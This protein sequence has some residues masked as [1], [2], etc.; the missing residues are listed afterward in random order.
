MQELCF[1]EDIM[2][3]VRPSKFC[4]K[5]VLKILILNFT[6]FFGA[7]AQ[8]FQKTLVLYRAFFQVCRQYSFNLT[9]FE[10][11]KPN[12][13]YSE[14]HLEYLHKGRQNKRGNSKKPVFKEGTL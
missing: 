9:K 1:L 7:R 6:N 8:L 3:L 4:E 14:K 12:I 5:P 10:D 2:M 11:R 13:T